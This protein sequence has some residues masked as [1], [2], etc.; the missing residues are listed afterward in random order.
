M[1]AATTRPSLHPQERAALRALCDRAPER[2]HTGGASFLSLP[3]VL[4][5]RD[6][7]TPWMSD[8]HPWR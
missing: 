5:G 8:E 6:L 1:L 2:L 3:L 4:V 7:S